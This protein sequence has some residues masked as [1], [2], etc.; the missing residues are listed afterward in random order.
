MIWSG[1]PG[2]HELPVCVKLLYKVCSQ[3]YHDIVIKKLHFRRFHY[4]DCSYWMGHLNVIFVLWS[5]RFFGLPYA[6]VVLTTLCYALG[7]G[8][9]GL[10]FFTG[11][12]GCVGASQAYPFVVHV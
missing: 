10:S 1:P 7:W 9:S 6:W 2:Y 12:K 11:L 4:L 8:I 5:L 3:S